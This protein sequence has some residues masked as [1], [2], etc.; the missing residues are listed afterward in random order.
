MSHTGPL[1]YSYCSGIDLYLTVIFFPGRLDEIVKTKEDSAYSRLSHYNKGLKLLKESL[2]SE[3]KR[4]KG[5][6]RSQ[7]SQLPVSAA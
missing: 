6:K 2:E 5:D 7:R 4:N 1:K 3:K